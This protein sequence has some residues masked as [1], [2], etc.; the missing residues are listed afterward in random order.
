MSTEEEIAS[1][2]G[3]EEAAGRV[4][5][6]VWWLDG[7]RGAAALYVVCHHIWLS[8]Y[9]GF[10]HDD[11]PWLLGWLLYGHLGVAVF[12]VVSGYSLSLRPLKHG[13]HLP[14]GIR[15]FARERAWRILPPYWI[16]LVLSVLI[17]GNVGFKSIAVNGLLLQDVV[18]NTSPNGAFWSIAV[19]AQIYLLFPLLLWMFRRHGP[20]AA[21]AAVTVFVTTCHVVALHGGATLH[22][23]EDFTPQL[24]VLFVFGMWAAT[25]PVR[26]LVAPISLPL[27]LGS[28]AL[29]V[30]TIVALGPESTVGNYFGIDLLFGVAFAACCVHMTKRPASR[31]ARV[32]GSRLPVALGAFSYSLYLIHVP[33]IR[34]LKEHIVLHHAASPE[35]TFVLLAVLALPASIVLARLFY[36]AFERPFFRRRSWTA[37]APV[38]KTR[39]LRPQTTRGP[40]DV[41]DVL[42][43]ERD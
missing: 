21:V 4:V 33:V 43:V 37:W 9:P 28:T 42:P 17:I 41:D 38:L 36:V 8:V 13:H 1:V 19:E 10:P 16:A 5:G 11:G 27:A 20:W 22:R 39:S 15:G 34:W 12:I 2:S 32:L 31:G 23:V 25:P 7:V 24:L 18:Q 6:R 3:A 30:A 26:R 35:W 14:T 40:V 29:C